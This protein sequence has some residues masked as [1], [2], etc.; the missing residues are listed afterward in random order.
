MLVIVASLM[1]DPPKPAESTG[2]D[3]PEHFAAYA[4]M[5]LWFAQ[6]LYEEPSAV[7]MALAFVML[8]TA[9]ECL[10]GLSGYRTF[11]YGDMGANTVGVLF[12][13][14]LAQTRLS[15]SLT[16]VEDSVLCFVQ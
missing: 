8:G 10:Q 1:P 7:A 12:G 13:L 6:D 16:V 9:L 2:S 15:R 4:F 14:L 3:K 5:M 11:E